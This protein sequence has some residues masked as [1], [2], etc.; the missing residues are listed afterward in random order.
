MKRMKIALVHD[1]IKEYG[2]AE[3]VLKAL[4][5]TYPDATVFTAFRVKGS[6]ADK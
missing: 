5:E 1:Y 4:T 6:T 2:G 3:R